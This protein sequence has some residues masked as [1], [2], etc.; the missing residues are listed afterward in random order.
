MKKK[1]NIARDKSPK[2]NLQR[3]KIKLVYIA[4]GGI[5]GEYM[6]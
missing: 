4:G 6:I 2:K 1:I 5:S 3:G